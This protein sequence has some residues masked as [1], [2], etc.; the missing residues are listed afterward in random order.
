MHSLTELKQHIESH[1]K[2]SPTEFSGAKLVYA[3]V[4]FSLLSS[5]HGDTWTAV[6]KDSISKYDTSEL[7]SRIS[8]LLLKGRR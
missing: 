1:H 7:K 6:R 5:P 3:N 4:T 2:T 8:E